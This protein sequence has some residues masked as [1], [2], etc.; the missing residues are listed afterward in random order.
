MGPGNSGTRSHATASFGPPI[1]AHTRKRFQTQ[2]LCSLSDSF[3]PYT[4]IRWGLSE[5]FIA[6][7]GIR[8]A[9]GGVR[10]AFFVRNWGQIKYIPGKALRV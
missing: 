6:E 5:S 4:V 1:N 9:R 8:K 2:T 7:I 3:C 10:R